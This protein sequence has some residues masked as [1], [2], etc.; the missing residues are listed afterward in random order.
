MLLENLEKLKLKSIAS[1]KVNGVI[2][3]EN[4]SIILQ[5]FQYRIIIKLRNST[6]K[7]NQEEWKHINTQKL[8]VNVQFRIIHYT[9]KAKMSIN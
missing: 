7:G 1:G 9:L 2:I 3:L 8:Y 5:N 4:N 6:P